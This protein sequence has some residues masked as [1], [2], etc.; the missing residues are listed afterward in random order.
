MAAAVACVGAWYFQRRLGGVTGDCLGAV[1]IVAEI[2]VL[3]VYAA[4]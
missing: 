2:A 1:V 3:G 4:S